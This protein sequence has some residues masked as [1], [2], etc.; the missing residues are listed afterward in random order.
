MPFPSPLLN[1]TQDI[2]C[3]FAEKYG[4]EFTITSAV[5]TIED[6]NGNKIRDN[7][8][9]YIINHDVFYT[10]TFTEANGYSGDTTYLV[11][12]TAQLETIVNQYTE[13]FED[14]IYVI[15]TS[16][17]VDINALVQK[18]RIYIDDM[19]ER[20]TR[21]VIGMAD[22]TRTKFRLQHR[23]VGE[24]TVTIRVNGTEV[25]D[26]YLDRDE[27]VFDTAPPLNAVIVADYSFYQY[28]T[29]FL[30]LCV[31]NAVDYLKDLIGLDWGELRGNVWLVESNDRLESI[32]LAAAV[33]EFVQMQMV[34]LPAAISFGDIGVRVSLRGAV[35][36]RKQVVEQVR[37]ILFDKINEYRSSELEFGVVI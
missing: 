10:E 30:E 12:F 4:N 19:G 8:S 6:L 35:G 11:T 2:V 15:D 31:K 26:F 28:S 33:L 29:S 20:T 3:T 24:G 17:Y 25:T 36:E 23:N 7:V 18:L 21:N 9:C 13:I 1:E 32:I 5:V 14:T 37:N 16:P 27:I 22:G 34:Q